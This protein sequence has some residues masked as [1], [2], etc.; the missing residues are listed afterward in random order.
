MIGTVANK[1]ISSLFIGNYWVSWS[2]LHVMSIVHTIVMSPKQKQ[3]DQLTH[4]HTF[5]SWARFFR[6]GKD[7]LKN[8]RTSKMKVVTSNYIK[9]NIYNSLFV[10]ISI[11]EWL[12][13]CSLLS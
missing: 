6:R 7:L 5:F 11:N 1:Y 10:Q 8:N 3:G 13:T 9:K 2:G 12:R 4:S